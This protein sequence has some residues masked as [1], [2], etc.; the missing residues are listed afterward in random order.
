MKPVAPNRV[1]SK[2]SEQLK[3]AEGRSPCWRSADTTASFLC[4]RKAR[5]YNKPIGESEET[6][7]KNRVT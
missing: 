5:F 4:G 3:K 2:A 7:K 6:A 1:S